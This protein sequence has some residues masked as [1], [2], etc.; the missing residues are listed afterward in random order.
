MSNDMQNY[1]E[2][3]EKSMVRLHRGDIVTGKVINVTDNEIM[4]N[5]GYKSDGVI[6]RDEISNEPNVNPRSLANIGD[7]IKVLVMKLDDGEG[8]LLLSKKRVDVQKGWDDIEKIHETNA[9]METKVIEVVKGGLISIS[10][11]IR[12][13]IPASQVSDTY[14]ENLEA[15]IGKTFNTKVLEFDRRKNKVVLSR[16]VVLTQERE[17]LKKEILKTIEVGKRVTGEVKNITNFG[18]FVDIGGIDGLIHISDMAWNRVKHPSDVL[19]VGEKV[20]VEILDFNKETEKLSLGLK[21]TQP[22]P[23]DLIDEKYKIGDIVEG[24]VV[25]MVDYGAFVELEAGLDGLVHISEISD[26]Y[27]QKPAQ[28]LEIGQI[29]MVKILDIDA[30]QK[31]ISLSIT[32]ANKVEDPEETQ[33]VTDDQVTIGDVINTLPEE[34]KES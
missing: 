25:R 19:K 9:L 6:P 8:N 10:R 13:F 31:R 15:F 27:I 20:E 12:C 29:V 4:V 16:K 30:E 11:G 23:W 33:L 32:A 1:M 24:K 34:N 18:A 28:E 5:V 21:Q 7:E 14:V 26:K 3:I 22:Q 17:E 2:E